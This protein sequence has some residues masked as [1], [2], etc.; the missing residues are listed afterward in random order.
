M[1]NPVVVEKAVRL[2]MAS[3]Q[4]TSRIGQLVQHFSQLIEQAELAQGA[5]LPSIRAAAKEFEVSTFTVVQAY[6]LPGRAGLCRGPQG[7]RFFCR[8]CITERRAAT[9]CGTA[10]GC[11]L[12]FG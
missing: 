6:D 5:R 8:A 3:T 4:K 9:Q 2:P 12:A 11:L 10:E 1:T 7:R